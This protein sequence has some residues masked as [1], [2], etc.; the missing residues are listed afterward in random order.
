MRKGGRRARTDA[1]FELR[2]EDRGALL[3]D[4]TG[5]AVATASGRE[6][7]RPR[8]L[9]VD[10]DANIRRLLRDD[11]EAAGYRVLEARDGREALELA[12]QKRPDLLIL[13]VLMPEVNGFEVAAVLRSDPR[14]MGIPILMLTVVEEQERA[15]RLGVDRYLTK[16]IDTARLLR[17]V[18]AL[19]EKG[20]SGACWSS[21]TMAAAARLTD[22]LVAARPPRASTASASEGLEQARTTRPTCGRRRQAGRG[23]IWSACSC[24]R[25]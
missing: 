23:A 4:L 1:R 5:Q 20:V 21:T 15:F 22:A 6:R 7:D 25:V 2:T 19:I 3:A 11:L 14:T 13:D 10:D 17:E 24:R 8:I 12:R 18:E 16:P 9:V